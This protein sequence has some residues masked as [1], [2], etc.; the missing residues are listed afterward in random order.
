MRAMDPRSLLP[1]V[2]VPTW[3]EVLAWPQ[4]HAARTRAL[5]I[6]R[7]WIVPF[8]K[9]AADFLFGGE[10]PQAP[11]GPE[12]GLEEMI[13]EKPPH[14]L[15]ATLL[16]LTGM[17][18]FIV[19]TAAL[20]HVEI[21]VQS[22]GQLN[23][24]VPPT[25]IQPMER[26]IVRSLKVKV[27][28]SVRKGQSLA[29]LDATFA[30]ADV[31]ALRTRYKALLAQTRRME[32]EW[33]GKPFEIQSPGDVDE[34]LQAALM[35]QRQA[36]LASRLRAFD[37]ELN[38]FE[39]NARTIDG[40]R[41]TLSQQLAVVLEI[42]DMRNRLYKL[43]SGSRMQLLVSQDA[44]LRAERE[45]RDAVDRLTELQFATLSKRAERQAFLDDWQRSLLEELDRQ[46]AEATRV[47]EA[48]TKAERMHDLISVVSPVDGVVMDIAKRS[49]GSVLREAEPLMSIMPSGAELIAEVL[50]SSADIGYA[51]IGDEVV[52]K[53][54]A[55]P[56]QKHGMLKGRLIS[57]GEESFTPGGAPAV[58]ESNGPTLRQPTGVFH[59]AR[60]AIVDT[61]L[62][63]LPK[64]VRLLAGMTVAGE[65]K[66]GTRRVISYFLSPV[67]RG[68]NE[69]IRE[70]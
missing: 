41:N 46:R 24:D 48:L 17:C 34:A 60:V 23:I 21:I 26:A 13:A 39:A 40:Q 2:R 32:A 47:K 6:H 14:V 11:Q 3:R 37:E 38:R 67:T 4:V 36:Q 18:F 29:T 55:F 64:G 51:R 33:S 8:G 45:H 16:I 66:V 22:T 35:R 54:D 56:Y 27:G 61:H 49:V 62:E 52:L 31:S 19:I 70:P 69:S 10:E 59:R 68:L 25:I 58:G 5:E 65:I 7:Q 57:V 9:R 63:H 30:E 42:E 1:D 12:A 20:V 53:V 43:Q 44:R 15:R 50:I 28:E